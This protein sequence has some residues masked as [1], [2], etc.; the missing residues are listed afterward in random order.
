M[1]DGPSCPPP[2]RG[3]RTLIDDPRLPDCLLTPLK[4]RM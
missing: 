4:R 2:V 3:G 1:T